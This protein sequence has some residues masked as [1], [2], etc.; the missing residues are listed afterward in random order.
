ME[1]DEIKKILPHRPPFLFVDKVVNWTDKRIE[2]I[3][4]VSINEDYFNGHFPNFPL[5]PGVIMIEAMAQV[6][7]ILIAKLIGQE[8]KVPETLPLFLGVDK[9]RFRKMVRPGDQLKIIC[10][11]IMLKGRVAKLQG[12]VFVGE[13]IACEAE[14]LIG[15]DIR[16]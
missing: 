1:I 10:E 11:I 14:L 5:L 16:R 2:A 7:G 12:K 13:E 4:N 9:A 6:G 3:K 15:F 8:F